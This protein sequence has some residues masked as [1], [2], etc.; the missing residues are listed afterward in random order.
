MGRVGRRALATNVDEH[1]RERSVEPFGE[2]SWPV[3]GKE[4][5]TVWKRENARF[6]GVAGGG[7]VGGVVGIRGVLR[8]S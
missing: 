2:G 6:V 4:S 7:T 1:G 5:A 8:T 3:R